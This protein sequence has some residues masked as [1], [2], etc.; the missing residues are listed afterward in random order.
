MKTKLAIAAAASLALSSAMTMNAAALAGDPAACQAQAEIDCALFVPVG[1]ANWAHCVE[2][3]TAICIE[4]QAT[5]T[6]PG[7]LLKSKAE[8]L[9]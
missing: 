5:P 7:D 2:Q 3:L 6:L 9:F 1:S 8:D 4:Y